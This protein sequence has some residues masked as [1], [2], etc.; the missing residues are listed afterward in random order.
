MDLSKFFKAKNIAIVGVS[1]DP[2]KIGHVIFRNLIDGSFRGNIFLVNP[3]AYQILNK[4][5]YKTLTDIQEEIELAVIAV[6]AKLILN[7]IKD[8]GKK[9]IENVVIISSGFKEIGN[10]KLEE[11]V[12]LLLNKFNIKCI[13]VNCLGC[14]DAY[15]KLDSMF[16]PRYRLKRPKPGGISFISQSGAVGSAILDLTTNQNYGISKFVSYGNA[17]NVDESDILEYLG[18][19]KE[20]KV[21]CM[22]LEGVK[23]GKR[24]LKAAKKVSKIKPIVAIKAGITEEGNKA[25]ISHTGTLAGNSEIYYSAFKQSN[26]IKANSL[27]EMFDFARI[28]E[29]TII[30]KGNKIQI[31]TNG[32]GYGIL[33]TDNIIKNNLRL[34]Q[35]N[36]KN[37]SLLKKTF[38]ALVIVGN[39]MDLIGDATTERYRLALEICLN[40]DNV[41]IILLIVL[42]QTPLIDTSI[43]DII[44][45]ANDLKKKPI[46]VVSTGGEFTDVLKKSLEDN[47]VANFTF[48]ER[49]VIAIKAL[50]DYYSRK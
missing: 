45:E 17:T 37:I 27:E 33:T 23:D 41:D 28:L 38:S 6:P 4:K 3:N 30:P 15:T 14:Y 48:P 50:T 18:E 36:K 22:Y 9:K 11:E 13:G 47:G 46:I 29:K 32:G 31:I 2:K 34:A 12:K 35:L 43:I 26:I 19:D 1:K 21:I 8:C 20:T 25:V 39:P 7:I 49:A 10:E 44:T 42:Y 16:I 24:F 5:V 40:D